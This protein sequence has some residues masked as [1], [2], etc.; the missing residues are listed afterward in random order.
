[1]RPRVVF[2][3]LMAPAPEPTPR[4][5]M[6][7]RI[8]SD[9]NIPISRPTLIVP[10]L[11]SPKV[12][13]FC[14]TI[15]VGRDIGIFASD[16]ILSDMTLLGVGSGAGAIGGGNTTLG[17]LGVGYIYSD[18]IPQIIHASAKYGGVQ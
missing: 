7:E 10:Q 4:S 16:A 12:R 5:V 3:P 2:P 6:S 17:R 8:A 18:W 13:K 11:L 1:M 15:K 9:A 14:G